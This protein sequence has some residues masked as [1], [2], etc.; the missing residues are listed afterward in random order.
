MYS[1]EIAPERKG[2]NKCPIVE[3]GKDDASMTE[4]EEKN[5]SQSEAAEKR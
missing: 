5:C 2:N 3:S 4:K 1:A